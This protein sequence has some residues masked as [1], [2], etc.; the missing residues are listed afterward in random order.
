MRSGHYDVQPSSERTMA[1]TQS[2]SLGRTFLVVLVSAGLAWILGVM[3]ES[4]IWSGL[5]RVVFDLF[6][7]RR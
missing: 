6:A 7:D 4:D 2:Q 3:T 1:R 5:A